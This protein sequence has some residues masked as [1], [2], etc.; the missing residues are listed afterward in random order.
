MLDQ[1]TDQQLVSRNTLHRLDH[2]LPQT[3]IAELRHGML[4]S[5]N[6]L[7]E[8]AVLEHLV[9]RALCTLKSSEIR[10]IASKRVD[11]AG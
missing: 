1:V 11:I 8:R 5:H 3:G 7:T 6:K 4:R 10:V 2:Q 9:V